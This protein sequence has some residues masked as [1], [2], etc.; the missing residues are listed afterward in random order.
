MLRF[1]FEYCRH[2]CTEMLT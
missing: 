1:Y 2:C